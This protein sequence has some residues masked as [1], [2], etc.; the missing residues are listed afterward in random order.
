MP[1]QIKKPLTHFACKAAQPKAAIY[2]LYAGNGLYLE[3]KPHGSKL[4]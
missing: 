4:W 2:R 1:R 3:I